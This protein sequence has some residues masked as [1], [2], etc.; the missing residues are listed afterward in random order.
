MFDHDA[1]CE[2]EVCEEGQRAASW[3]L[4]ETMA[5]EMFGESCNAK[6]A[7]EDERL[8][9][10]RRDD[11]MSDMH[12]EA[13]VV[14]E[15]AGPTPKK[16]KVAKP[17][18]SCKKQDQKPQVASRNGTPRA[19]PGSGKK[20]DQKPQA[21]ACNGTPRRAATIDKDPPRITRLA[22]VVGGFIYK[23]A[24]IQVDEVKKTFLVLLYPTR[25]YFKH[26][27]YKSTY[28]QGRAGRATAW[29]SA[30]EWVDEQRAREGARRG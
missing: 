13:G 14:D 16:R 28:T 15:G 20:P 30:L 21:A 8:A 17:A 23:G 4:S 26:F 6:K 12:E 9:A 22:G 24:K 19:T 10:L 5:T 3:L 2:C 29:T 7:T 18:G 1:G 25:V 27:S 11:E